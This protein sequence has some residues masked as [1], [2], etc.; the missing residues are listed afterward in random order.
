MFA[1]M[2]SYQNNLED[3]VAERTSQLDEEKRKT[4]SLLHR[5]LPKYVNQFNCYTFC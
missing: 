3:L 2:E 1:M 5:M 4:E